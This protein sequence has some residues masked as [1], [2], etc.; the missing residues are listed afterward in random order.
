MKYTVEVKWGS[1]LFAD[2][3]ISKSTEYTFRSWKEAITFRDENELKGSIFERLGYNEPMK[4]V[5]SVSESVTEEEF[6]A[7][8]ETDEEE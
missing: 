8:L 7:T 6:L 4:Y 1:V 2:K 3:T 5:L